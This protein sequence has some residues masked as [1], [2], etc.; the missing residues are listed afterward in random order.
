MNNVIRFPRERTQAAKIERAF[1]HYRRLRKLYEET[2]AERR[3]IFRR[4]VP[5]YAQ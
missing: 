1:A 3:A 4:D 5:R 2:R